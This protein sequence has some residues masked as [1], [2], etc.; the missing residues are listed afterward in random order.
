MKIFKYTIPAFAYWALVAI[1]PVLVTVLLW[2]VAHQ[3]NQTVAMSTLLSKASS[4]GLF[5]QPGVA[6]TALQ[7]INSGSSDAILANTIVVVTMAILGLLLVLKT[8][9]RKTPVK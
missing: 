9:A 3:L 6:D 1:P 8:E 4:S 7:A 2:W 5:A